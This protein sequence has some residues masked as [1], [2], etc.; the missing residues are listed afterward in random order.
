MLV[1][2]NDLVPPP[3]PTVTVGVRFSPAELRAIDSELARLK[4]SA[5]GLNVSRAEVVRICVLGHLKL[6]AAP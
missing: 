5:P 1:P 4:K 6:D 2:M 3:S